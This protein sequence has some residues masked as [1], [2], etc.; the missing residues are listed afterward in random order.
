MTA[1]R[2]H[3]KLQDFPISCLRGGGDGSKKVFLLHGNSSSAGIFARQFESDWGRIQKL[4][5]MDLPGHGQS[6]NASNPVH[7]YSFDELARTVRCFIAEAEYEDALFVGWSLGG[8]LLMEIAES[9]PRATGF[10]LVAAPPIR[11]MDCFSAAFLPHPAMAFLYQ[12]NLSPD[13]ENRWI[14]DLIEP[15]A[16]GEKEGLD[17][18]KRTDPAFRPCLGASLANGGFRDERAVLD[19]LNRPCAFVLGADDPLINR[20]YFQTVDSPAFWRRSV[21]IIPDSTHAP[22][23]QNAKAFNSLLMEFQRDC[24][25][26]R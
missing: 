13:E 14:Q 24:E 22:M 8:H 4:L 5:A 6:A 1:I 9:L 2:S 16:G 25:A 19:Q 21:Q 23:W 11:G 20:D 3:L 7:Q 26:V 10:M 17:D 15:K 18:L 12:E